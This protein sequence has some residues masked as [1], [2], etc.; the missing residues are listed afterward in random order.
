MGDRALGETTP[1]PLVEATR[2][3]LRFATPD[4]LF[5]GSFEWV[6]A[7]VASLAFIARWQ[8]KADIIKIIAVCAR[9]GLIHRLTI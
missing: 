7:V 6:Q 2:G 3:E 5:D 8:Y 9:V 4:A 1:N